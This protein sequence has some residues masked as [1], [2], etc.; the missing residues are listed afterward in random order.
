M[1]KI[2]IDKITN[3][4]IEI[5]KKQGTDHE[6]AS[7]V[8]E[9]LIEANLT[10]HDSH[11]VSYFQKY[12]DR[13]KQG[14]IKVNAVPKIVKETP[15]TAYIDGNWAFGQIVAKTVMELSTTVPKT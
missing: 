15:G 3:L 4:G 9:T 11:G 6:R 10:G 2:Q 7:F 1:K 8:V 13:I 12:S 14:Y 5:F